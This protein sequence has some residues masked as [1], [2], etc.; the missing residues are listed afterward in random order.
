MELNKY[1]TLKDGLFWGALIFFMVTL[2]LAWIFESPVW[3]LVPVILVI[4]IFLLKDLSLLFY[5]LLLS[6]P[7]SSEIDIAPGMAWTPQ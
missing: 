1:I 5:L 6:I 2:C 3:V 4:G 7:F